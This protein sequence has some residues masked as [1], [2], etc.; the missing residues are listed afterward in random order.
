MSD[1][2]SMQQQHMTRT[3]TMD[4]LDS[5]HVSRHQSNP[6]PMQ[7]GQFSGESFVWVYDNMFVI[8]LQYTV[9]YQV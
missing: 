1:A 4:T 6:N 3:H 7:S 8:V 9:V 5:G 2:T